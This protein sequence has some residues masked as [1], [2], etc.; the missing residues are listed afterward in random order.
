MIGIGSIDY[1]GREV[2][3]SAIGKLE[4]PESRGCSNSVQ[5]QRLWN[6]GSQQAKS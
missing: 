4:N 5:V 1:G 2:P 3:G 6:Q